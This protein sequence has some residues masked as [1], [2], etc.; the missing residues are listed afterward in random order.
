[1][2]YN[3]LY[4][5][6]GEKQF[7]KAYSHPINHGQVPIL[8]NGRYNLD[9]HDFYEV[10]LGTT[11]RF[12]LLRIDATP[13]RYEEGMNI[14][15]FTPDDCPNGSPKDR[16]IVMCSLLRFFPDDAS[17]KSFL[18]SLGI[19]PTDDPWNSILKHNRTQIA[20]YR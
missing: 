10:L 5:F 16:W 8:V 6:C 13:I 20:Y 9:Q 18:Y 17:F 4:C 3:G 19:N 12:M 2:G 7:E 11:D 1:M 15:P 14:S